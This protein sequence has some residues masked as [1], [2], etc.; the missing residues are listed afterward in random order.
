MF[1][2]HYRFALYFYGESILQHLMKLFDLVVVKLVELITVLVTLF[3]LT[4]FSL[5]TL[6]LWSLRVGAYST[7]V[8]DTNPA[9]PAKVL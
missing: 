5:T 3:R 4:N 8:L 9:L 2:K 1:F 6:V 7:V